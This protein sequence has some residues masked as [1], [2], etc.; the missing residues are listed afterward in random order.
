M[1]AD[2]DSES[3]EAESNNFSYMR[4]RDWKAKR[5]AK[6]T[7]SRLCVSLKIGTGSATLFC[8][9]TVRTAPFH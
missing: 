3:D 5:P 2:S 9:L 8:P 1:R 6:D 4:H 7:P